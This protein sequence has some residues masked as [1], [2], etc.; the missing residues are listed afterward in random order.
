[1]PDDIFSE[2]L[3]WLNFRGSCYGR[4]WYVLWPFGINIYGHL[5]YFVVIWCILW[6]FGHLVYFSRFGMLYQ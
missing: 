6:P 3:I 1:M 5:V 4:C 2:I